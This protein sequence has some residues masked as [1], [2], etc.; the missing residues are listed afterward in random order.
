VVGAHYDSRAASTNST[1][2]RAPGAVDNGSGSAA[3]LEFARVWNN[4][5][6]QHRYTI[7]LQFFCGEEQGLVGS[8][9]QARSYSNPTSSIKAMINADMLGYAL[10][11]A[12]PTTL[13]QGFKDR[14]ISTSLTQLAVNVT[15]E[16][17]RLLTANSSSC[18]S[19]YQ[20]YY[21]VGVDAV[22]FF[23]NQGAAADYP[24]YHTSNDLPTYVNWTQQTLETQAVIA[25]VLTVAEML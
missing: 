24:A 20:S 8:R 9:A 23:Q 25:T 6:P 14:Y 10:P 3:L 1:T 16:Y 19:D 5:R 18:C 7:Q 12:T 15:R 21:E 13:T 4:T 11:S 17:T 2:Q 22:G